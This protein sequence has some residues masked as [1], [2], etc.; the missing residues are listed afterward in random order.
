M[1]GTAFMRLL[2]RLKYLFQRGRREQEL[3]DELAFHRALAVQEQRDAGLSPEL[4]RSAVARQMGDTTL[5]REDAHHVWFP[6]AVESLLQDLHYAWRG[7]IRSKALLAVACLSLGLSTGFGT[8]LFSV[9]NALIL[10]PVTAKR[11]D[12]LLRF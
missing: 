8:A 10:Q 5:A 1:K 6:A 3:A 12:A 9:V 2:R 7:L 4:A 11:P